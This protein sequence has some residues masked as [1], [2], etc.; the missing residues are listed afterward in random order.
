MTK[1][2]YLMYES[3][4]CKNKAIETSDTD[5]KKFFYQ[6]SVGFKRK[7]DKLTIEEASTVIF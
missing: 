7:A 3:D 5:L 4:N 2:E 6:A 1:F